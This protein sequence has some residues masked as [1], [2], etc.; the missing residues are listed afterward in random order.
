MA[1]NKQ[2]P[3]YALGL[4]FNIGIIHPASHLVIPDALAL[5][6]SLTRQIFNYFSLWGMLKMDKRIDAIVC[7]W[8]E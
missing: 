5:K 8:N 3:L 2:Y 4:T 1:L 7:V 6:T